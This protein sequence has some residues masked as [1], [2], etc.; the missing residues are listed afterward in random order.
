M[1]AAPGGNRALPRADL[2][3][4]PGTGGRSDAAGSLWPGVMAWRRQLCWRLGR[5]NPAQLWWAVQ[6]Q[7]G[8][9]KAQSST[10]RP[11][12]ATS[13]GIHGDGSPRRA[14]ASEAARSPPSVS[15]PSPAHMRIAAG[16]GSA[17]AAASSPP[18]PST[19]SRTAKL[20]VMRVSSPVRTVRPLKRSGA[21]TKAAPIATLIPAK[22]PTISRGLTLAMEQKLVP[23]ARFAT[24]NPQSGIGRDG[25]L[26]VVAG[27]YRL[28]RCISWSETSDSPDADRLAGARP[29]DRR[30]GH[31]PGSPGPRHLGRQP[32]RGRTP[33]LVTTVSETGRAWH[34]SR[35]NL[36]W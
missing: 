10:A 26:L 34:A 36:W 24:S 5:A 22:A 31:H 12:V 23:S 6:A 20:R 13:A 8:A 32:R 25:L 7:S 21:M 33:R 1:C 2:S 19:T 16:E 27:R 30:F 9:E 4:R 18:I 28:R 35:T 29:A 15:A 17:A 3:T 14:P 11:A